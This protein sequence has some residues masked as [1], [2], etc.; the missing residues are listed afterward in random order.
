MYPAASEHRNATAPLTS[1]GFPAR[2]R[3]A[4][5]IKKSLAASGIFSVM[6]VSMRPG[7]TALTL[8]FLEPNSFASDLH[9]PIRPAFEAAYAACPALPD[10]SDDA[11]HEHDRTR[12]LL[13]HRLRDGAAQI[14]RRLE[15]HVEHVVDRF[16][17]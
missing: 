2:P 1:S 7:A 4:C 17:L 12:A 11:R 10:D 15:V 3:A 8:I 13:H 6:A 14:E 9:R 16:G 5:F